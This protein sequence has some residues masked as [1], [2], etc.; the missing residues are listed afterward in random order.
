[1]R[2]EITEILP[3]G[4]PYRSRIIEMASDIQNYM[5]DSDFTNNIFTNKILRHTQ[6]IPHTHLSRY[7]EIDRNGSFII[8]AS[9]FEN[10]T[11]QRRGERLA[12]FCIT[13]PMFIQ[14]VHVNN[15]KEVTGIIRYYES[16]GLPMCVKQVQDI[17]NY[18]DL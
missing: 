10:D 1:M 12:E 14:N 6:R 7:Y 15:V 18:V 5:R 9:I 8:Y 2:V 4:E 16:K 11:S 13:V 3:W 17:M